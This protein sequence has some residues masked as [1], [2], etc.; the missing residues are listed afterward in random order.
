MFKIIATDNFFTADQTDKYNNRKRNKNS[1]QDEKWRILKESTHSTNW[2]D[3]NFF[4]S[5]DSSN[6]KVQNIFNN[7]DLDENTLERKTGVF[8]GKIDD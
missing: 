8:I 1:C 5:Y 4:R 3:K 2:L 7:T 6:I